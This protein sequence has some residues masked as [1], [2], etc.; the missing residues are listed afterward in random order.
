MRINWTK[1]YTP[2]E[3]H[4]MLTEL[5]K[6][7]E[8]CEV[9]EEDSNVIF[10]AFEEDNCYE[11]FDKRE[12]LQ[13]DYSSLVAAGRAIS[14]V[15]SDLIKEEPV[16]AGCFKTS[17]IMLDCS[18]NA[19]MK[20]E[21]F[22]EWLRQLCL[23]GHNMAMLYTEDTF[24]LPNEPYFGYLRGAYSADELKEIDAYAANLGIEMIPCFQTVGHLAQ[25]LKWPA[26]K[27][28]SDDGYCVMVDE[29]DTYVLIEKMIKFWSEVFKS[30][31]IH[32]GMDEC[33]S[34]GLG[35]RLK[36]YGYERDFDLFNRHLRKVIDICKKYDKK[37]MIW[38]DMFFR[39]GAST[40]DGEYDP[41]FVIPDEVVKAIPQDCEF[42]YWEYEKTKAKT[43]E[44]WINQHKKLGHTP[45]LAAASWALD[46]WYN[47][48]ITEPSVFAG[49]EGSINTGVTEALYCVWG[50]DGAMCNID[51][52]VAGFAY[53]AEKTYIDEDVVVDTDKIAKRFKV[54]TGMD[55]DAIRKAA[56]LADPTDVSGSDYIKSSAVM[57]D[58]PIYG[59][60]LQNIRA[61]QHDILSIIS[62]KYAGIANSL[63]K[64]SD[65]S[66]KHAYAQ[67]NFM[68]LKTQ[69]IED[70]SVAYY[71]KDKEKLSVVQKDIITV[72][73]ALKVLSSSY[74]KNWMNHNKPF[75]FETLQIRFAGQVERFYELE[76]LLVDYIENHIKIEQ[77]EGNMPYAPIG[78]LPGYFYSSIGL[79]T[80]IR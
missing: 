77:L 1:E 72:I 10:T 28:I 9:R 11:V 33:W 6:Y 36:K 30:D 63:K 20:V 47:K 4:G 8:I 48:N 38:S 26:Y 34:L 56:E 50:D 66:I 7:Y 3:L 27:D 41:N 45:M 16:A 18:R 71:A 61:K 42:V 54:I 68:S 51:S 64:Y 65:E 12:I 76:R 17:G 19:V 35:A 31:R 25:V 44:T 73:E 79:P 29:P 75:G 74:R 37:P 49:I 39:M 80:N 15:L 23:M 22:K 58:D 32:I 46:L 43:Y 59:I 13:I 14:T 67:A 21:K 60:Y 55:Y 24:E 40:N 70:L 52:V 78:D 57:N 2:N 53:A 69:L 5:G 62:K